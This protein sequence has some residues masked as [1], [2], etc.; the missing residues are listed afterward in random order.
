MEPLT[1]LML[2][3]DSEHLPF[4]IQQWV[5]GEEFDLSQRRVEY[6][7]QIEFT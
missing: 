2:F 4:H 7:L 1:P 5:E 3:L 6:G